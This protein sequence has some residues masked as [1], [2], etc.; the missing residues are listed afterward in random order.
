MSD[1]GSI[2]DFFDTIGDLV[3]SFIAIIPDFLQ[4][5]VLAF[6]A[7]SALYLVVGRN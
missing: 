7:I 5:L 4:P 1:F 2:I 3:K 6:V